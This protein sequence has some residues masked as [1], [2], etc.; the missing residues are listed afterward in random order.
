MPYN[1]LDDNELL[2]QPWESSNLNWCVGLLKGVKE[3][4]SFDLLLSKSLRGCILLSSTPFFSQVQIF[5]I[6]KGILTSL[7][8]CFLCFT[9]SAL[10]LK[11]SAGAKMTNEQRKK[12]YNYPWHFHM[13]TNTHLGSLLMMIVLLLLLLLLPLLH[14]SL[15]WP[16]IS[17]MKSCTAIDNSRM[18][19]FVHNTQTSLKK[20][21][22]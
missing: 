5:Y 18:G 10:V 3:V 21:L 1:V 19:H 22:G 4:R 16:K 8:V 2:R 12:I 9:F 7:S 13:Y 14:G 11:V 6:P 15:W 17:F 20:F